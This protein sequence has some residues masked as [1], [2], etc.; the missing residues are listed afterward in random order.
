VSA[1]PARRHL[2]L[3]DGETGEIVESR[4]LTDLQARVEKLAGDLK[5]AEKDLRAK[6]RIITELTRDKA[7]ERLEHPRYE[8]AVR[9]AKY[10]WRKCKASNPR[11]NY[12]T[13]DRLDAV[14]ALMDIEEI[15]IDADTGKKR[16]QPHYTLGHFKAAIDGGWFDPYITVHR[17]GKEERHN[18]LSQICKDATR[19]DRSIAKSP[20]P[21]QPID[22]DRDR[23][24]LGVE[25]SKVT[26]SSAVHRHMEVH[27]GGEQSHTGR[28]LRSWR[29]PGGDWGVRRH[30]REVGPPSP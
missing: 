26:A 27:Y 9:V 6:R 16:R 11:V 23:S 4:E 7:R 13:P 15:V 14:L 17:N 10:W 24:N 1:E 2:Q 25:G 19:F 21:V 5:A 28:P 12:R 8:D 3:V 30:G 22:T 29:V 20:T 18:D